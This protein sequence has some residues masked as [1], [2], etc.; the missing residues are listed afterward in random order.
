MLVGSI[1][2]PALLLLL[3]ARPY[4]LP[5]LIVA[6]ALVAGSAACARLAFDS[7]LQ[8]DAHDAVRGR[9]IARFETHFQLV[10]VAGGI[11]AVALP[12]GE[13]ISGR[14]GVFLMA[15]V[16]LF[17]GLAY[18]G[19]VRSHDATLAATLVDTV[20]ALGTSDYSPSPPPFDGA[21]PRQDED[22]SGASDEVGTP[23]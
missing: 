22:S 11:I 21:A 19:A 1:T 10:W 6:A 18:F 7:L 2:I 20:A 8:R 9:A 23:P 12:V 16:M 14:L 17:A 3:L 4:G 15:I 13:A 5:A